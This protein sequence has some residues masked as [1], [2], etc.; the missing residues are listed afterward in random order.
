SHSYIR[1]DAVWCQ[2]PAGVAD[3][4]GE[5]M[6]LCP[7]LPCPFDRKLKLACTLCAQ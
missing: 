6:P 7:L 1:Q 4:R 5:K 3:G 2:T